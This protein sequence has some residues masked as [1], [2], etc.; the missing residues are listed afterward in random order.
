MK[1]IEL[2]TIVSCISFSGKR[3]DKVLAQLFKEYSRSYLKKLILINQ[4]LVNK[5]IVN[6]PDKKI[7]VGEIITIYPIL[8]DLKFNFPENIPLNIIY[9]D[10]DILVINKPAGL[11]VHPGSGNNTGTILNALL[12]HYKN[13][14]YLPRAGIV[15]RL[16]KDTTGL[17]VVAKTIYAYN[18]LLKILKKR[19][20][21]REYQGIVKG[22]MISG[23]IINA[24]I[25]RHHMKRTSMMVHSLGKTSITHYKIINRFK[26]HTHISIRL[27]TGRTHQIRV[28]M[29]YIK[30]PLVG[31]PCYK[32]I[33]RG[34]NYKKNEDINKIYTF[35][36]QALHAS[37]ISF[38]HPVTQN[39]MSWTVSLPEDMKKLLVYLQNT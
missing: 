39:L 35:P 23:G 28:H 22:N 19:K 24:P 33:E 7:S 1:K 17:M 20:I 29:L 31:D 16:D 10:N 5:S 12:Y 2:S 6:Q 34:I 15:H 18:Y 8:K 30:H 14:K 3:L 21:T 26:Y 25:M 27:E 38:V 11:V 32:G 36:R 4:V 13:I 37:H 9:E